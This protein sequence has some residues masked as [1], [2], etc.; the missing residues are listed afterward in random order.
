MEINKIQKNKD[1][2]FGKQNEKK[3]LEILKKNNNTIKKYKYKYSTFDFY[4]RDENKKKVIEYELKSRNIK[5]NQYPTIICGL[6]KFEYAIKRLLKGIRPIFLFY[7]TDGL[8]YWELID[9]DKQ[10]NQY[11]FGKICNKQRNDKTDDG[12]YIKMKYLKKYI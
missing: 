7:F 6:N 2:R 12:L 3:V 4:L 8:Y 9:V 5:Y 11:S 1:L 10:K